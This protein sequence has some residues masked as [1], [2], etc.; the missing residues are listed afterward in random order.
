MN[1]DREQ[2]KKWGCE[3]IIRDFYFER[4]VEMIITA[5]LLVVSSL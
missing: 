4:G 3:E 2:E 1:Q 5:T